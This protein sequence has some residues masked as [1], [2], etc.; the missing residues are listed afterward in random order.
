MD[1]SSPAASSGLPSDLAQDLAD[2][3]SSLLAPL[4]SSPQLSIS[5]LQ[6]WLVYIDAVVL[7]SAGGNLYDVVAMTARMAVGD[8]LIPRTKP[9][10]YKA[11]EADLTSQVVEEAGIKGLL[12]GDKGRRDEGTKTVDFELLDREAGQGMIWQDREKIPVVVTLNLVRL[13]SLAA[14]G[15]LLTM[16]SSTGGRFWT[17]R[18]PRSR[19]PRAG[20]SS[21]SQTP[22][23]SSA[24]SIRPVRARSNRTG[25]S[26]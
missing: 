2:F 5:P 3:L 21:A 6:H 20:S 17:R 22:G 23:S 11:P 18:W 15:A 12:R 1:G 8:V 13:P 4:A 24:T 19:W 10:I 14:R 26:S 9:A 16:T 25:S 7:S